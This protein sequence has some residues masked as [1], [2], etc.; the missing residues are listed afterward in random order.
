MKVGGLWSRCEPVSNREICLQERN[1]AAGGYC[2]SSENPFMPETSAIFRVNKGINWDGRVKLLGL[3]L[4]LIISVSS[5]V[6][7]FL[8]RK[9]PSWHQEDSTRA[10][11]YFSSGQWRADVRTLVAAFE[12]VLDWASGTPAATRSPTNQLVSPPRQ[13]VKGSIVSSH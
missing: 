3:G 1:G 4:L 10:G 6:L 9:V 5:I 12:Y 7:G 2:S 11:W 13:E 8:A